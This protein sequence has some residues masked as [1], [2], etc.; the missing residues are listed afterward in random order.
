[1]A[2]FSKNEKAGIVYDDVEIALSTLG[3]KAAIL[4]ESKIDSL[5]EQGFRV[6]KT[7]YW[8]EFL[9]KADGEG[10]LVVGLSCGQDAAHLAGAISADPQGQFDTPEEV[11]NEAAKRPV[12]PLYL[13]ARSALK[14]GTAGFANFDTQELKPQW[15]AREGGHFDWFVY[16]MD[17]GALTTGCTIRI[18]AKHF[19]V[20]L[21][22]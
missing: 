22:D 9:G 19:G 6:L 2:R 8:I 5:R 13:I 11:A 15:S 18:F 16:N 1:M 10:P 17:G 14:S 7:Q 4:S 20:W 12:W 3:S 21:D